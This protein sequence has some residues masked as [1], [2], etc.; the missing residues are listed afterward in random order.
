MVVETELK[1]NNEMLIMV[2]K[3]IKGQRENTIR[4]GKEVPLAPSSCDWQTLLL[5]AAY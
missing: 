1:P 4:C 5:P 2:Y 3:G